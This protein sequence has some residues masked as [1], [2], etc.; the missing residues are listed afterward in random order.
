[1]LEQLGDLMP[2]EPGE[3]SSDIVNRLTIDNYRD[4]KT[5]HSCID[6]N[7]LYQITF[8]YYSNNRPQ[9]S[10][11][12]W[13]MGGIDDYCEIVMDKYI[14]YYKARHKIISIIKTCSLLYLHYRNTMEIMYM[15]GGSFEKKKAREWNPILNPNKLP[16][17]PTPPKIPPPP[18][19]SPT[20]MP[21]QGNS[22]K[23]IKLINLMQN[24]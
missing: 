2:P 7:K 8:N 23:N 15:P 16:Q 20:Q 14:K 5:K 13:Y 10:L 11:A 1:M 9:W 3:A 18:P 17:V 22:V 6:M 12:A 19:N 24:K 4:F 21:P